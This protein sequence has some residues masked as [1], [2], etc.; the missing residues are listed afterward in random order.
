MPKAI[1]LSSRWFA[2]ALA[3][4][5]VL[6]CSHHTS[7]TDGGVDLGSSGYVLAVSPAQLGVRTHVGASGEP[8]LQYRFTSPA[9]LVGGGLPSELMSGKG[10]LAVLEVEL[11]QGAGST[12][13]NAMVST[14]VRDFDAPLFC[15][16]DTP[17]ANA[18]K[19]GYWTATLVAS[20][21]T[22]RAVQLGHSEVDNGR[23][24]MTPYHPVFGVFL[25][26]TDR[27]HTGDV[28]QFDYIGKLPASSTDW[29]MAPLVANCRYRSFTGTGTGTNG[30]AGA[31][32]VLQDS[33]VEP[34][35][36]TA[37]P[38]KFVRALAPLDVEVNVPFSVWVVVT[39]HYGNPS[40]LTGS[41]M[42]TGDVTAEL[43]FNNEWRKEL[44]GTS[45]ATAGPHKIVPV[46]AG[47]RSLY[48]YSM[49]TAGPPPVLR[50]VGDVHS[51]S[52][53]GGAQRKFIGD[54]VPGDHNGLFSRTHDALRYMQEVAGHDFGALSEHAE[55]WD[56]YTLP[57]AVAADAQ[58]STGGA[59]AGTHRT[60]PG[61]PNWFTLHQQIVESYDTQ[62]NG[63]FI[64]FP[65]FEWHGT[66]NTMTDTSPLHRIILFRDFSAD[67][68]NAPLPLL[69][70]DIANISPQCIVRFMALAGF[71]PDKVLIVPHMMQSANTN[72]DWD[73][74]YGTVG[75]VATRAQLDSYHKVG[76]VYSARAID[77]G[78]AY[79]KA[80]L[81]T[82]ET[83]DSATGRW[84]YR[85][86]WRQYGAHIGLIGSSD[87]HSQMP[88]VNDDID[89][90]GVNYHSNE[91]G[92]YAVVLSPTR[93]RGGIFA[94]LSARST[95]A[96][97]GVRAWLDYSVNGV[98]MGSQMTATATPMAASITLLAGMSIS[99]VELWT[100]QVGGAAGTYALVQTASPN[101]EQ[102][103][104]MVPLTNPVA[105]GGGTQEWLYYVRAFLKAPGSVVDADEAVWS[106]PIWIKWTN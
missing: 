43:Q 28:V 47:A 32:T 106:S 64:A 22:K 62:A 40:P 60:I 102:Y 77:Q 103:S 89:L 86:G 45:Y 97:S 98:P 92:G 90:D 9:D 30:Q 87:N 38:P 78:R 79:G 27:I 24:G 1:D 104:A 16:V 55:P 72:I 29:T 81:T 51:H 12:D 57:A 18:T 70:G 10:N 46:M 66:H 3:F 88:G 42:L 2:L 83:G 74:T 11:P 35:M 8:K 61:L 59:C 84:H 13:E 23:G 21:G 52:G 25:A 71:G 93:D 95:Y 63:A 69:A 14:G 37:D 41:V 105:V 80:T 19:D 4:A 67:M 17:C 91:P 20:D 94:G 73:L 58:F 75:T 36:L 85:Y 34:L 99:T 26:T 82:F 48:H 39:D 54:F 65:A 100:V 101:S 15:T 31:W 96:T 6:G 50:L 53:D 49:A 56:S 44:A 7:G 5:S 68:I 76:E 33:Q